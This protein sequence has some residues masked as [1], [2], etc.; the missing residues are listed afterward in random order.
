MHFAFIFVQIV[1][2]MV[3]TIS[4]LSLLFCVRNTPKCD[5]AFPVNREKISIPYSTQFIFAA[6]E[7]QK[8]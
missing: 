6:L 4:I 2:E 5:Q 8:H 7:F 3:E 1:V